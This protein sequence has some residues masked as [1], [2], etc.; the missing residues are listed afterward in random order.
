LSVLDRNGADPVSHILADPVS[1]T[2]C[3]DECTFFEYQRESNG[4]GS[5]RK[6]IG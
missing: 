3:S 5:V 1:H 6:L 4:N 2:W